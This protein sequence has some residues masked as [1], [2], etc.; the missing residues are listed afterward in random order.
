MAK[1]KVRSQAGALSDLLR[2]KQLTQKDAA[3]TSGI[4]RKTLRLIDRGEEVKRETL[5]RLKKNLRL[6]DNLRL[7]S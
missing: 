5:E 7:R 6:P 1:I 3:D 4:D 2:R